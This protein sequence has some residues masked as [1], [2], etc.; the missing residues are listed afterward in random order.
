MSLNFLS[1]IQE[2][3]LISTLFPATIPIWNNL[4]SQ[5]VRSKNIDAISLQKLMNVTFINFCNDIADHS[6]TYKS[7]AIIIIIIIIIVTSIITSQ[8]LAIL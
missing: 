1:Y 3:T 6:L 4:P 8:K 5:A 7:L 2:L